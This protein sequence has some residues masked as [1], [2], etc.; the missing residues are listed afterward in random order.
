MPDRRNSEERRARAAQIQDQHRRAER[1]RSMLIVGTAIG[2]AAV[3]VGTAVIAVM[4]EQDEQDR[5]EA[6]AK[7]PI[8]GV[9]EY[10]KLSRNHVN[11]PVD[12]P[13]TPAVGGDHAPIWANCGAY[14]SPVEPT[15]AVH[16]L[17]HGA[18]WVG[19][20]PGLPDEQVE[21]LTRVAD[22]NSYVLLSPVE[23]VPEPVTVSAWG[24]QLG[25]KTADDPRVAAFIQKYQQGPQTPEPGAAC[26]GGAGGM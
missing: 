2:V 9:E 18:V 17:E 8:D 11:T 4:G 14:T 23:G 15:Q 1:R 19:Y 22:S 10:K 7:Q 24:K 3:L 25:V 21:E 5:V 12:Y 13:Q 16:S 20:D 6:A 26:T